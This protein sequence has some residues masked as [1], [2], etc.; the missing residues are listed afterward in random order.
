MG[1]AVPV[2]GGACINPAILD[3]GKGWAK[4][5]ARCLGCTP[6]T[7]TAIPSLVSP[8]PPRIRLQ[9]AVAFQERTSTIEAK[10]QSF[11]PGKL[12]VVSAPCRTKLVL[13]SRCVFGARDDRLKGPY[14]V[15][16]TCFVST[17]V[18]DSSIQVRRGAWS[19]APYAVCFCV[20]VPSNST[21]DA[22][23]EIRCQRLRSATLRQEERN[24]T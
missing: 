13:L 22:M 9:K 6:S 3:Y 12:I 24:A 2:R 7:T 23:E 11:I 16:E 4:I 17:C 20:F 1:P 15:L 19:T 21:M 8:P 14:C 18:L 10:I 5:T